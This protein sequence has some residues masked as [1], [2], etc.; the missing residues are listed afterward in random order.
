M[1]LQTFSRGDDFVRVDYHMH[2]P[3]SD[4]ESSIEEYVEKALEMGLEEIAITDHVW[5]SSDWVD[6]YVEEIDEVNDRY[7]DIKLHSGLEAKVIDTDGSVDVSDED[8]EKVDFIM[9]VVHRYRPESSEP[10][11][12]SLN[13]GPERAAEEERNLTLE[14]L[15]N[16]KVDVIGHPSR[17]YYKFHYD[18]DAPHFSEE[19]IKDMIEKSRKVG[20][21]LEYN[22]RLPRYIREKLLEM[23][24]DEGIVFT[25]GSDSH[26]AERLEN[27]DHDH[28]KKA[29]ESR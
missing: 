4:G 19:Y 1:E 16:S 27:L 7:D 22:A 20:K 10:R 14:M 12:D 26:A 2:T 15:E 25:V 21:P 11:D 9:G 8:A 3:F 28:V 18:D 13:F 5:R 24:L 17:T 23:Y 29:I 6:D